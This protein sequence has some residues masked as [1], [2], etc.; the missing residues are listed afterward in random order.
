[1]SWL[2]PNRTETGKSGADIARLGGHVNTSGMT[3][4]QAEAA[5]AARN[6]ERER[7]QR[8]AVNKKKKN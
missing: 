8:E 5:V 1:M 3:H 4:Q 2:F 7:M 6:R